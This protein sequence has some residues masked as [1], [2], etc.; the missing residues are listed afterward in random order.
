MNEEYC[1]CCLR[2]SSPNHPVHRCVKCGLYCHL[3]CSDPVY[4]ENEWMDPFICFAC[5]KCA[6]CGTEV[7]FYGRWESCE[8]CGESIRCCE[9]CRESYKNGL[10]CNVC[11]HTV[12]EDESKETCIR[13]SECKCLVHMDCDGMIKNEKEENEN[14]LY[15]CPSC[16]RLKMKEV[17]NH[18]QCLDPRGV[19]EH[20][21]TEDIAPNYFDIVSRENVMCFEWMR[22]RVERKEY[23]DPQELR[24]DFE[25]MC[26]NA[27]VYNSVGDEVWECASGVFDG[28]ENELNTNLKGSICGKYGEKAITTR[29]MKMKSSVRPEASVNAKQA[30]LEASK[31]VRYIEKIKA[32]GS[33]LEPLSPLAPPYSV[34]ELGNVTERVSPQ[35]GYTIAMEACVSCGSLGD[36]DRMLFCGDCGEAYH[37]FCASLSGTVS[38]EMRRGWRC[39]NCKICEVCGLSL[40]SLLG[41]G[42][43]VCSC[44]R[45]DRAFHKACLKYSDENNLS[46]LVCGFC[47]DCK[48][49]GMHGSP[50]SWS[51]H[52]DYCR[53]CYLKE[54]RFRLCAVCG[55]PWSAS[56]SDMGFCEGCEQWIH[57]RCLSND[58]IEWQKCDLT[59]SPY[60]CN[61]CRSVVSPSND[62][63]PHT[64]LSTVRS[65]SAPINV[66]QERR[67]EL[68]IR[69]LI[70][71]DVLSQNVRSNA[72]NPLLLDL[73]RVVVRV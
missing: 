67:Q 21:I 24:D 64:P 3:S 25:L 44:N 28:G 61:R 5:S 55:R 34:I 69:E 10:F 54:E 18:L 42:D 59:R 48:K 7:S 27:F 41:D 37:V 43:A 47:F 19:F 73:A 33:K 52:K 53:N 20:P 15:S 29:T 11:L 35:Y 13:C 6:G 60:H 57:R 17:L 40:T 4:H 65:T 31:M 32:D 71:G 2:G 38:M 72:L 30:S 50:T 26:Y 23:K 66:I 12:S 1:W 9:E 22:N 70:Q 8:V 46:L 39:T 51:Y 45:C 68:R 14:D 36:R 62:S 49:C 16:R 56:D 63:L 58:M